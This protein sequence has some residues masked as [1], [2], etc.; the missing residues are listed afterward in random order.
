MNIQ[1]DQ[2]LPDLPVNSNLRR[3][4]AYIVPYGRRLALVLALSLAS[5][6]LALYL[7]YLTKDLVDRA[8]LGRDLDALRRVVVL[9]IAAG[10]AS[11][12]INVVSGLSYTETSARIL[13]DM[14][15]ALY[16]HLQRLSPRFYARTRLGDI[17]SR[18]N[19][20]IG[21]I[22]RVAAEAALAW[23]GNILFLAGTIAM[24]AW[25]DLRLFAVAVAAVP[26]SVGA[27]VV[28]RRRLE[29]RVR[30]LRERSA[31]IGSFLIETLQG[32]RLVVTSNAQEREVSRFRSANDAFIAALMA[33]QRA[34][35][36]AGGLPG[37]VLS[38]GT[39]GV[40]FYGGSRVIDGSMTLGTLAA[41]M[42]YQMRLMAP[43]QALMGLYAAVAT[44]RVSWHR[45]LELLDAPP[46]VHEPDL[47]VS[48][49]AVRGDIV[50]ENVTVSF[51][52]GV[53]VLEDASMHVRAGECVAVMGASGSGK[54]TI[55]DVILRLIEPDAGRVLL[56]GTDLRAFRL[57]DV[58]R[59]IVLAE[60]TPFV[61]HA[62][63]AENIRYA[64]PDAADVDII[65]AARAAGLDDQVRRWPQGYATIVGERG[66]ALSAGERQRVAI[67]RAILADPAVLILDEP[68]APL[69]RETERA[70]TEGLE[71]VMRGRTTII[72]THR[73]EL[74][75]RASR[76][77][78]LDGACL[79]D[80]VVA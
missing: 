14:R 73:P 55:A 12:A 1:E 51:D 27:L 41:F 52:R 16:R 20:D 40:F 47:P 11:F 74:A 5:T 6:A 21:E 48:V 80:P 44:A 31:D 76:I 33:M 7:P 64:R 77:I 50:L 2:K 65:A 25:L 68:T 54:S 35:Y 19:N 24:L 36:L 75:A 70:M 17:V 39:A 10:I 37:L 4:A 26:V 28:Y 61:F 79:A 78:T 53:P 23:V 34:T 30:A 13:F 38:F 67:A 46:E 45:V 63:I 22:Q 62:S 49:S 56:D 72:I 8:L 15:L 69:D 66:L 29:Q 9:F 42:A 43:I 18:L 3:I 71:R 60:Q 57:T 58:R 32:M 59:H